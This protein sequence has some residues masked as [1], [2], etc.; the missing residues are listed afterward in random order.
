[1]EA[2]SNLLE[3]HGQVRKLALEKA[4]NNFYAFVKLFAPIVL[5]E[6]F[7]PGRHI[8]YIA[9]KLQKVEEGKIRRLQVFISPGSM[10]SKLCSVLYPA[11][12]LGRHSN[13]PILQVSHSATLAETYGREVRDLTNDPLFKEVFPG[14]EL[15]QDV[16][17]AGRWETTAGGRYYAAGALAQIAGF[18]ARLAVLDDVL[19][20][21]TAK[22]KVERDSINAWYSKGL[23]T[24]LLPGGAVIIVNTR[25]H[26]DDM[27]GHLLREAA[28]NPKRDQWE[29]I[30]IPLVL[31][32]KSADLLG[33]PEGSSYWPEYWTEEDIASIKAE[34]TDEDYAAL[35]LQTP[36]VESGS[37]FK[38][39][40]FKI[41][42]E[43]KP[44]PCEFIVQTLDTANTAKSYSDYS[45]IQTWGVFHQIV[46]NH[47]GVES[48]VPCLILLH[49]LRGRWEY[50]DLRKKVAKEMERFRP[51]LMI[52]EKK[53]SGIS[54]VQDLRIS[55]APV[56]EYLPDRD[57][58]ARAYVATPLM[59]IGRVWIPDPSKKEWAKDLVTEC[60]QFQANGAHQY[61]DQVD[62]LAMAVIYLKN[63]WY[64]VH[65]DDPIW[66]AGSSKSKPTTYFT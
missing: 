20:E 49:S 45:V 38:D 27:S 56:E 66:G 55:G 21:Q 60:K 62:C 42:P 31:D 22:S 34:H 25:W 48:S 15:R 50:P 9:K 18:R 36:V 46:Q 54:L 44:P 40:Y 2:S 13:W 24:R 28:N 33:L 14:F 29:V 12:T 58:V 43:D 65:E 57:K 26:I 17:A 1:M 5:P 39:K 37:I 51:D 19:S 63:S 6:E 23:R 3:L 53:S 41:W 52:V 61:D 7:I 59:N 10:K 47:K 4:K 32:A 11:W 35:Y 30:S 8:K 16:K 64:L